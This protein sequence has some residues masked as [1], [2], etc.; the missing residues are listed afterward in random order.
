[1]IHSSITGKS[2][3]VALSSCNLVELTHFIANAALTLSESH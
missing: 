3:L 1:M 2:V